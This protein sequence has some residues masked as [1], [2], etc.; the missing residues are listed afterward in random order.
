MVLD[1]PEAE[2]PQRWRA[3]SRRVIRLWMAAFREASAPDDI[4]ETYL[5]PET[6]APHTR[7]QEGM[8]DLRVEDPQAQVRLV[9]RMLAAELD[10]S[11]AEDPRI[12]GALNDAIAH[13]SAECATDEQLEGFREIS[14]LHSA[15]EYRAALAKAQDLLSAYPYSKDALHSVARLHEIRGNLRQTLEHLVDTVA[16]EPMDPQ[17]WRSLAD[18]L[19]RMGSERESELAA[20]C[21]S[22]VRD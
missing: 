16:L 2:V 14:R 13:A 12:I 21:A 3:L 8:R 7:I 10:T 6:L 15:R 17:V 9:R 5:P 19:N 22:P 11:S 1:T 4:R 20:M 18:V